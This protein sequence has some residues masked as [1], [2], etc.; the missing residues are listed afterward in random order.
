MKEY[1]TLIDDDNREQ[2]FSLYEFLKTNCIEAN[3]II[4]DIE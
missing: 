1:I 4:Q 2:A 3:V